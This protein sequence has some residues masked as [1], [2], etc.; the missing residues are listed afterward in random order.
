MDI[1]EFAERLTRVE[2]RAKSNT[3]Q[4]NELKPVVSEIHTMSKTMV[5]LLG[6]MRHTNDTVNDLKKDVTGLGEKVDALEQEPADAWKKMKQ[7]AIDA[8]I[9]AVAGGF[10]VA[11]V[12]M[13]AQYIK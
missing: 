7:R 2:E 6:E 11:A 13:I 5:E 8:A 10:V 3:H 4:I 1:T 12:T 9:G